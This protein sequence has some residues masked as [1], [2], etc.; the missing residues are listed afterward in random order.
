MLAADNVRGNP[1]KDY[2]TI[3]DSMVNLSKYYKAK[4]LIFIC[5]GGH[6]KARKISDNI[7]IKFI[8]FIREADLMAKYY[9]C[10]DVYVHAAKAESSCKAV[11]E[12]MACGVPIVATAVGGIPEQVE[13]GINGFL[14]RP[15]EPQEMALRIQTIL[16]ND[17]L[18]AK[19]SREA[20]RSSLRFDLNR[21][22]D[23]FLALYDCLIKKQQEVMSAV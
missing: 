22:A 13:D 11:T 12:A 21:Q 8:G 14:T 17:D 20:V 4:E 6:G 5:V 3:E 18:K 9:S 2:R 23:E 7:T 16:E 15:G 19:M 10:A 1:W